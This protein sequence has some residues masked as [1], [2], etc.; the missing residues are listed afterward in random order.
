MLSA[1]SVLNGS[2]LYLRETSVELLL[3]G[4][5]VIKQCITNKGKAYKGRK[6]A[7]K[8]NAEYRYMQA[9]MHNLFLA[10]GAVNAMRSNYNFQ[11]QLMN[12]WDK[13]HPVSEWECT[14]SK[15]IASIQK[16]RNLV[17]ENRCN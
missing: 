13:M 10:I 9:D 3:S 7:N 2:M 4:V 17:V 6:C 16:N 1:Q 8:A 14:R 11:M 12:A 15:K 5:K